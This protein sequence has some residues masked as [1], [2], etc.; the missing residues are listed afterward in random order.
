MKNNRISLWSCVACGGA[1]LVAGHLLDKSEKKDKAKKQKLDLKGKTVETIIEDNKQVQQE[2]D[3]WKKKY[4]ELDNKIKKRDE[5]IK[6]VTDKLKDPNL[7]K[8]EREELEEKLALLIANQDEDKRERDNILDKIKQLNERIKNNN[9]IISGTT[10]NLDDKHWV[11]DL[12]TLE[13]ILIAGGCYV[14]YKL[15]KDDKK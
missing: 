13:N 7:P 14:V 4:D 5:E 3:E 6:K 9:S 11:W 8:K 15:L 10:S 12:F 1:G 2:T